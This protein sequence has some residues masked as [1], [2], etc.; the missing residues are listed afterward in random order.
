MVC[1]GCGTPAEAGVRFCPR[2]G[3]SIYREATQPPAWMPLTGPSPAPLPAARGR[4]AC[5]LQTLGILWCVYAGYRIMH[6]IFGMLM[7]HSVL[8]HGD[9]WGD[10]WPGSGG[11]HLSWLAP[12]VPVLGILTILWAALAAV[13]GYSL[14]AR[15]P[16]GRTLALVVAVLTL[17]K[18]PV[19]TA[20]GIYTLWVLA[21]ERSEREY[22][23]LV[24]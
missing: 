8:L 9:Q 17:I 3:V 13:A 12:L 16:W 11:F 5:H 20:L 10:G 23:A 6:G 18:I 2:C 1:S 4:V 24:D 15:K 14:L 22:Q 7:L 21:P 19:G